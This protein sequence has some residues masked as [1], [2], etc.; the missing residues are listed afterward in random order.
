ALRRYIGGD[1][2]VLLAASAVL[3]DKP[4]KGEVVLTLTHQRLLVTQE[5]R[6]LHRVR[7]YVCAAVPDLVNVT[8]S[9]DPRAV[10][11]E[12][13]FTVDGRRH[14]FLIQVPDRHQVWR[15]DAVFGQ[16]FLQPLQFAF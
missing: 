3:A 15:L 12:L 2:P 6:F 5:G 7:P 11:M 9:A 8:W 4:W 16:L 14:R 13:A 1:A 10:I